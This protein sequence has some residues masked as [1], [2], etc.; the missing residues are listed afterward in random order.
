MENRQ[1]VHI[2]N[3]IEEINREWDLTLLEEEALQKVLKLI[4]EMNI[5]K[6]EK[7]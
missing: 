6:L 2:Q 5:T 1:T 7:I 3:W 4:K